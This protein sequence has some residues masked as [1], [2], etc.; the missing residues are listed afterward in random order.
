MEGSY[1][2]RVTSHWKKEYVGASRIANTHR[3]YW[4]EVGVQTE[5]QSWWLDCKT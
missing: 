4:S 1:G 2:R 5:V 3:S